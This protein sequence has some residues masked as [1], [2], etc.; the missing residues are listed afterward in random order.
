MDVLET[1]HV[2]TDTLISSLRKFTVILAVS[3]M[4]DR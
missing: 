3:F 2:L 1:K 4:L